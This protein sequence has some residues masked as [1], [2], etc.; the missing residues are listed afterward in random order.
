MFNETPARSVVKALSWRILAT[1]TTG[2]LVWVF[3]GRWDVA[4][5]VGAMEM[6]AKLLL[7]FVHERI[8]NRLSFGRLDVGVAHDS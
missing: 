7:Y 3:T 1:L 4:F 8:W 5:A 2:L 6:L